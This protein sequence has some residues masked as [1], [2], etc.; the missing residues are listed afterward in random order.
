MI[1][2]TA[3]PWIEAPLRRYVDDAR[4]R[5]ALLLHPS[6]QVLAQ[7]GFT[8]AVDVSS[9]CALAAAAFATAGELGRQLE[10]R[11]FGRLHHAGTEKQIFLAQASTSRGQFV[12]VTVF[13]AESSLGLVRVYF[14]DLCKALAAAAPVPVGRPTPALAANFEAELNANLSALFG[15]GKEATHA[16]PRRTPSGL[17]RALPVSRPVQAKSHKTPP[18]GR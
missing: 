13:D 4:A 2:S 16:A 8:R 11:A 9:A 7:A 3:E 14:D 15:R 12:C 1:I 6:G 18:R 5:M 10:G 17:R